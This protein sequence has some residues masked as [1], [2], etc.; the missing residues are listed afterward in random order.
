[1]ADKAVARRCVVWIALFAVVAGGGCGADNEIHFT[2]ATH[3]PFR[4]LDFSSTADV[5]NVRALERVSRAH[6]NA[7]GY[8]RLLGGVAKVSCTG[9]SR[10][11][12]AGM[13]IDARPYAPNTHFF[14]CRNYFGDNE[15]AEGPGVTVVSADGHHWEFAHL[16][17]G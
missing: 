11:E 4:P 10:S 8:G 15:H 16:V 14:F 2:T 6:L 3:E 12:V 17:G 1:M 13:F 9:T 5:R 7:A